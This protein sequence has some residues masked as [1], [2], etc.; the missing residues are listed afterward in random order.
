VSTM[1]AT[2]AVPT[3]VVLP[4]PKAILWLGGTMLFA[5]ALYYFIGIDQGATSVFG[6]NMYIHEFVHDARHFLGFPCH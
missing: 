4:L 5:L 1:P 6:D 2:T 3:P